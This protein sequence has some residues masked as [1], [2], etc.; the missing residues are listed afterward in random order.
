[1]LHP[2]NVQGSENPTIGPHVYSGIDGYAYA[3]YGSTFISLGNLH[4]ISYSVHREKYPV[5]RLGHTHAVGYTRGARTIAG[6]L[7]FVN[8]Q[9]AA[10]SRLFK[11]FKYDSNDSNNPAL[12]ILTDQ[13][14]PFDI[15][16]F[17]RSEGA[18]FSIIRI[19][20]IDISDEGGV[21][22]AEESYTETT[23]QYVARDISLLEQIPISIDKDDIVTMG[24]ANSLTAKFNKAITEYTGA[25]RLEQYMDNLSPVYIKHEDPRDLLAVR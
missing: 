7:V 12:S 4:T 8:F 3:V 9:S 10:L 2:F 15:L 18:D 22:G 6:S 1:M 13:L 16:V 5:R 17:F 14:P 19:T 24:S 21:F 25:V 23:M 20:G 11:F